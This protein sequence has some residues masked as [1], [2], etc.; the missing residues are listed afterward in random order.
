MDWQVAY[1]V[2]LNFKHIF[3]SELSKAYVPGDQTGELEG[4]QENH[5][6]HAVGRKAVDKECLT[7]LSLISDCGQYRNLYLCCLVL[8]AVG[9]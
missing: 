7:P 4:L 6:C 5:K 9:I 8:L 1:M 2:T 3:V